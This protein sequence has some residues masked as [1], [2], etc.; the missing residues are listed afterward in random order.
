MFPDMEIHPMLIMSCDTLALPLEVESILTLI[1]W[2]HGLQKI[3]MLK[4][5][6]MVNVHGLPG[7]DFMNSMAMILA[8]LVMDGI[9]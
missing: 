3:H 4:L 7:E 5:A 1:T 9:V 8:L 6:Y 2:R